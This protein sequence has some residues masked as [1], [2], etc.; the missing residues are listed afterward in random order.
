[1]YVCVT[2]CMCGCAD[3]FDVLR[4]TSMKLLFNGR[5][6]SPDHQTPV[7]SQAVSFNGQV[8][9]LNRL[10]PYQIVLTERAR[11]D[12]IRAYNLAPSRVVVIHHSMPVRQ[13]TRSVGLGVQLRAKLGIPP[14]DATVVGFAAVL[15]E[16]KGIDFLLKIVPEVIA[17]SPV[18]S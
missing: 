18:R 17:L 14:R 13:F 6:S 3:S 9:T 10:F 11:L 4:E 16:A 12:M 7:L 2:L 8:K 5:L 15:Q 1:M